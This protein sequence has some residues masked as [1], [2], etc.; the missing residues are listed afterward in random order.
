MWFIYNLNTTFIRCEYTWAAIHT[1]TALH[2]YCSV[3]QF[4]PL[5]PLVPVSHFLHSEPPFFTYLEIPFLV[6]VVLISINTRP[7]LVIDCPSLAPYPPFPLPTAPTVHVTCFQ[8]RHHNISYI[9]WYRCGLWIGVV[10]VVGSPNF[11]SQK[12]WMWLRI[13][14]CTVRRNSL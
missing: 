9:V 12:V 11:Y 10:W 4:P 5:L 3:N 14:M 2:E 7:W 8:R 1:R 6:I 13:E